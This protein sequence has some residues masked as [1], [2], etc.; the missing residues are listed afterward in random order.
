[1]HLDAFAGDSFEDQAPAGGGR[2]AAPAAGVR[3]VAPAPLAESRRAGGS[4][5]GEAARPRWTVL[6]AIVLFHVLAI[7]AL[8]TAR[9][10][11]NLNEHQQRLTTF[12]VTPPPPPPPPSEPLPADP[13]VQAAAPVVAPAPPLELPRPA[14]IAAVPVEMAART[15]AV[16]PLAVAPPAPPAAPAQAVSAPVVPPDFNAAQLNNPKPAYPFLSKRAHE[17]G[18][19]W[20]KVLVGAD[21]TAKQVQLSETSGFG[22]LDEA[23][24]KT[25]RRWRFVPASQAGQ[26]R[27]AWVLVPITFAL[28]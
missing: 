22:R 26:P 10:Q 6:G 21:G 5:Y 18:V 14:Q 11:A 12:S 17:E 20:L 4:A 16:A 27:E 25:V 15:T 24:A 2:D 1:M 9:Y 8:A 3:L 19:V 23:A 7:A 28:G 13:V